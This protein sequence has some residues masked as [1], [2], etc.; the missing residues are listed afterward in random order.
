MMLQAVIVDFPNLSDLSKLGDPGH[1]HRHNPRGRPER[2][3]PNQLSDLGRPTS[4]HKGGT[5]REMGL[6]PTTAI[7]PT[8]T[9]S[10]SRQGA[11]Q[12]KVCPSPTRKTRS[13]LQVTSGSNPASMRAASTSNPHRTRTNKKTLQSPRPLNYP[14]GRNVRLPC[15]CGHATHYASTDGTLRQVVPDPPKGNVH[16]LPRVAWVPYCE[17]SCPDNDHP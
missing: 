7:N 9:Q 13:H 12:R 14:A 5:D 16:P 15:A 3:N 11:P 4:S 17:G 8:P 1:F 2:R 10:S 6:N